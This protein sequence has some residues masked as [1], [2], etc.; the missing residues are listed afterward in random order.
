MSQDNVQ[1]DTQQN[2]IKSS[3]K[4]YQSLEEAV[5]GGSDTNNSDVA[6][7]QPG[8]KEESA[9]AET[10]QPNEEVAKTDDND[11]KRYQYWQSQ[12]D[13]MKNELETVKAQ[14]T[15]LSKKSENV[16]NVAQEESAPTVEQFPDPP[17]R[18]NKPSNFNRDEALADPSSESAKYM[19]SVDSWRDDMNEYNSLKSQYQ[20]T[21]LQEK[22]DAIENTRQEEIKRAQHQQQVEKQTS[23]VREYVMGHHGLSEADAQNFVKTMSDPASINIDNLVQLYRMNSG[24]PVAKPV[25]PSADFKQTQNAQQVPSPMGV[26]PSGASSGDN[27]SMEDKIMDT[28]IGNFNGKNPWK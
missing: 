10:G 16:N 15:D 23:E 8:Q 13:K 9:P 20:T 22:L 2:E 26:M 11:T 1:S 18:P 19:D 6:F 25:E 27:S 17:S 12:A 7:P 28:M 24:Q 3:N 5:F 4:E 21:V 14:V